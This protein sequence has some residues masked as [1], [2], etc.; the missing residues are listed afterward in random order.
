FDLRAVCV[1]RKHRA[2]LIVREAAA[3]RER[4]QL[5]ARA[6]PSAL[7][8]IRA[9]Q[10]IDQRPGVAALLRPCDQA[11]RVACIRLP[12]DPVEV[13]GDTDLCADGSHPRIDF[14]GARLSAEFLLEIRRTWNTLHRQIRVELKRMPAYGG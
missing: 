3:G 8:E 4:G 11:M 5:V 6:D 10:T 1:R 2:R 9:E 14:N 12:C 7:D 13:E